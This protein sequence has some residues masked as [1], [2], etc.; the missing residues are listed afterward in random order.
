MPECSIR[1]NCMGFFC[2]SCPPTGPAVP[3]QTRF[4]QCCAA[5]KVPAAHI[6]V[7]ETRLFHGGFQPHS[8]PAIPLPRGQK[9]P[10][11]GNHPTQKSLV[12][13]RC[14]TRKMEI[15]INVCWVFRNERLVCIYTSSVMGRPWES[16]TP[17]EMTHSQAVRDLPISEGGMSCP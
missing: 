6:P 3:F 4:I 15:R 8:L 14:R 13:Q 10:C 16:A 11:R 17:P 5:F 7:G 12:V 9:F 2:R 1:L